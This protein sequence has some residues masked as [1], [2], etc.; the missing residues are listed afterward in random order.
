MT[1]HHQSRCASTSRQ[2]E[3]KRSTAR[4]GDA[5]MTWVTVSAVVAVSPIGMSGDAE[6]D[7]LRRD[8]VMS[9]LRQLGV[10]RIGSSSNDVLV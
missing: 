10:S 8:E 6:A 5:T 1:R 4:S 9:V 2:H 7:E 3:G